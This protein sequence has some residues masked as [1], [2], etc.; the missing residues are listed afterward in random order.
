MSFKGAFWIN[1]GG[2]EYEI[3]MQCWVWHANLLNRCITDRQFSLEKARKAGWLDEMD[4][5][6]SWYTA[7]DRFKAAGMLPK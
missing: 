3:R 7:F 1:M 2:G 6:A 4:A 5:N